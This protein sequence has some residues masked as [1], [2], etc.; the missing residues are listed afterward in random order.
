MNPD[1]ETC[2]IPKTPLEIYGT[3]R[4]LNPKGALPQQ[5]WKID[6][7]ISTPLPLELIMDVDFLML[8]STS[9]KQ[10]QESQKGEKKKILERI[11]EIVHERGKMHNPITNSGGVMVGTVHSFGSCFL[12]VHAEEKQECVVGARIIPVV[13]LTALPLL[14]HHCCDLEGDKILLKGKAVVFAGMR[15][16]IIP[17]EMSTSLALASIDISSL[18]PQVQRT[19]LDILNKRG[20]L[21]LTKKSPVIHVLVI[22]LGKAGMT[23]LYT[24]KELQELH[25]HPM[26]ILA[27]DYDKEKVNK[28]KELGLVTAAETIDAREASTLFSFVA[29]HTEGEGCDLVINVVNVPGTE[30]SSVLSVRQGVYRGSIIFFSMSTHFAHAALATDGVGKD[31]TMIIGNGVADR[32]FTA[33]FALLQKYPTLSAFVDIQ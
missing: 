21:S 12:D 29:D 24:L 9:M 2:I 4:V 1:E 20:F 32:Q 33:M 7:K 22:G 19:L 14:I 25:P 3:Y 15:I 28:I 26:K 10:L 8:D 18:V 31:A 17:Q 30:S 16:C 6:N 11:E 27:V 13:S 5:A 23:A